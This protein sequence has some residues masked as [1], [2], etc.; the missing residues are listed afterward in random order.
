MMK[1]TRSFLYDPQS[2]QIRYEQARKMRE[3]GA[4]FAQIARALGY[5]L[6]HTSRPARQAAQAQPQA[7]A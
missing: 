6:L 5:M 1:R 3:R 4:T 7:V 2:V